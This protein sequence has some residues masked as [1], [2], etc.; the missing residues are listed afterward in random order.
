MSRQKAYIGKIVSASGIGRV[1]VVEAVINSRTLV[2]VLNINRGEGYDPKSG[3]YKGVR[4]TSKDKDGNVVN[5]WHRGENRAF[6]TT[7]TVHVN[8]LSN[9]GD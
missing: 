2:N 5:N 1:K 7:D 3:T 4:H 8:T 6:G 9:E